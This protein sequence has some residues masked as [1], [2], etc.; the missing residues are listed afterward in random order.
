MDVTF[1]EGKSIA[2]LPITDPIHKPCPNMAGLEDYDPKKTERALFLIAK[3][4]EKHGIKKRVESTQ[5]TH[6]HAF[7]EI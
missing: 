5:K 4:R 6:Y 3:L 7:D 1:K 2:D